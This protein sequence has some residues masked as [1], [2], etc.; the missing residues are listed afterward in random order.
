[1]NSIQN[2]I[3]KIKSEIEEDFKHYFQGSFIK[4]SINPDSI[5]DFSKEQYSSITDNLLENKI[6]QQN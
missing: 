6:Q 5:A 1:M 3:I 2:R 4:I